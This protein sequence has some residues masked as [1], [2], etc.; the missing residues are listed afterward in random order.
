MNDDSKYG[1]L[2]PEPIDSIECI[3][4]SSNYIRKPK[5]TEKN[6]LKL[7]IDTLES[8]I[9]DDTKVSKLVSNKFGVGNYDFIVK[10]SE[11]SEE[12]D[13]KDKDTIE[14]NDNIKRI[15]KE[16]IMDNYPGEPPTNPIIPK[17]LKNPLQR[18]QVVE[19]EADVE[20]TD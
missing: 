8:K 2:L 5:I 13:T 7:I 6:G 10:S 17:R 4:I 11:G 16:I 15:I 18:I 9:D 19:K 14:I 3:P 1:E 20:N 12:D